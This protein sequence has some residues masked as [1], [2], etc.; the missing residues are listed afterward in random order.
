M[1]SD[2]NTDLVSDNKHVIETFFCINRACTSIYVT[3]YSVDFSFHNQTS[4]QEHAK[5]WYDL[6]LDN[7]A[8]ETLT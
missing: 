2:I 8:T 4:K 7:F 3:V 5:F 1:T 6:H